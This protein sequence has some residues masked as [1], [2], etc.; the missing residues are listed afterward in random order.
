MHRCDTN[1][2]GKPDGLNKRGIPEVS[3]FSAA[4]V[5]FMSDHRQ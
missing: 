5:A 2:K 4:R 1:K 3:F